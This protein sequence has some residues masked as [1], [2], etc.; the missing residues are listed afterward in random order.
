MHWLADT[1]LVIHFVVAAFIALGLLLI[2]I[3]RLRA[4]HWVHHRRLRILHAGLMVFVALEAVI[5][6]TCPLTT[7]EA[8]LRGSQA[9]ESFW[10]EQI[11]RLLFWHLPLSF[12]LIL[13]LAC[14]A[15]V[16]WLWFFCRPRPK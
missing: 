2:P 11:S 1:V 8:Y 14:A 4:W 5:G 3:G 15:W 6:M 13:Y 12:F 7:L 9:H 10:A 16:I